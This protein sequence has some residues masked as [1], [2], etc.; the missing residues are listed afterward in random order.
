MTTINVYTC[1]DTNN[2]HRDQFLSVIPIIRPLID[3]R[4]QLNELEGNRLRELLSA[5]TVFSETC[6]WRT[7]GEL[8]AIILFNPN[9]P[10][11]THR[12]AVKLQQ[13]QYVHLLRRYLLLKYRDESESCDKCMRLLTSLYDLHALSLNK[14]KNCLETDPRIAAPYPVTREFHNLCY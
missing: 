13:Q 11:L 14:F 10:N 2:G 4:N 1:P 8:T 7:S 5:A 6:I 9:R 3:Y 12:N